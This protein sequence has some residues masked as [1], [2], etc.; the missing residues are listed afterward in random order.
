MASYAIQVSPCTCCSRTK[1]CPR[2]AAT[3]PGAGAVRGNRSQLE[4]RFN[5][6]TMRPNTRIDAPQPQ[7][8]RGQPA[9]P[10][11]T[12]LPRQ[13]F[14]SASSVRF[15]I[16][17]GARLCWFRRCDAHLRVGEVAGH[18]YVAFG[19]IDGRSRGR[20]ARGKVQ[21]RRQQVIE[22]YACRTPVREACPREEVN[23]C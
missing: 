2:R 3:I 21:R 8:D 18:G 20:G 15:E 17:R 12:K 6:G 7:K 22:F 11:P 16:A 5:P 10:P 1:M 23:K 4:A 19:H 14:T 13:P 9:G